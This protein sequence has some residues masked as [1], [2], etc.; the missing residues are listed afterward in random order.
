MNS[1]ESGHSKSELYYP[2]EETLNQ[3]TSI[4]LFPDFKD[5]K[6]KKIN[7]LFTR[8][9]V[10]RSVWEKTVPEVFGTALGL[11]PYSRPRAQF[12]FPIRT[13]RPVNNISSQVYRACR[14]RRSSQL[15]GN[16]SLTNYRKL[17]IAWFVSI[18]NCKTKFVVILRYVTLQYDTLRTIQYVTLQYYLIS[19]DSVLN[20]N[21]TIT[22]R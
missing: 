20:V 16:R 6:S 5:K 8:L 19:Y 15:W 7:M 13:S 2:E 18:T 10:G 9:H 21:V 4:N 3:M 1:D 12:F 14:I 22:L 17:H 11:G